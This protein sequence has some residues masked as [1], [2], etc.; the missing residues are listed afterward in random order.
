ME[1][2]HLCKG[3]HSYESKKGATWKYLTC[4]K[5]FTNAKVRKMLYALEVPDTFET[6]K[7]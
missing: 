7:S 3:V 1:K 6:L 2:P 5:E 4:V